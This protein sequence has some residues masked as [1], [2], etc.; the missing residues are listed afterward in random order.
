MVAGALFRFLLLSI[1]V[2][3]VSSP[4]LRAAT[5][6]D[7]ERWCMDVVLSM[8]S[9]GKSPD[10]VRMGCVVVWFMG[11]SLRIVCCGSGGLLNRLAWIVLGG[12]VGLLLFRFGVFPG[13]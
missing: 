8:T 12:L 4:S 3:C 7:H 13:E 10:A 5:L 1:I 9:T 2:N 11:F 6:S